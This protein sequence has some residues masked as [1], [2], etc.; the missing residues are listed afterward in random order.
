[1]TH[2]TAQL[3]GGDRGVRRVKGHSLAL[4]GHHPP[5]ESQGSRL[6]SLL[7]WAA[8]QGSSSRGGTGASDEGPNMSTRSSMADYMG[9]GKR[10]GGMD[11]CACECVCVM[12]GHV[13]GGWKES[14]FQ[15]QVQVSEFNHVILD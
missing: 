11:V 9:R 12:R 15:G 7:D 13:E 1:M 3:K 10:W 14:V 4:T 2:D 5:T 8:F 6:R